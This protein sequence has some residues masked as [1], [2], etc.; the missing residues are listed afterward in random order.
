MRVRLAALVA[1]L[2]VSVLVP[3]RPAHAQTDGEWHISLTPYVWLAGM[4]GRLGFADGIADVD[5]SYGDVL[6]KRDITVRALLEA[7]RDRWWAR[8]DITYVSMSDERAI[9]E[10]SGGD[11]IFAHDQTVLQPELGYTVYEMESDGGI[12]LLVGGRY[13]HPKL[14]VTS[15]AATGSVDIA[16]GSRSWFDATVGARVRV[17]PAPRWPLSALGDVGAGGSKLTWQATG[18][19]GFDLSTCCAL[20][21]AYRHLDIDYDRD[22]L[23]YD[24]YLSGFALGLGIRF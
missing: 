22:Q 20:I 21:G 8:L 5:L 1:T 19:V 11:V 12:D 7:R 13:W 4:N 6:D 14:D 9:D 2:G 24:T 15:S 18:A 16:S 23:I 10:G 17:T 3:A